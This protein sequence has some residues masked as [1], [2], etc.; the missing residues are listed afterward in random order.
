MSQ[1]GPI[2][3]HCGEKK[4]QGIRTANSAR[5]RTQGNNAFEMGRRTK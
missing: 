4:L 2:I 5:E 3:V 1:M